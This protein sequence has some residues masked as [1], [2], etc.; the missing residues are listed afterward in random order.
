MKVGLK[1]QY[2]QWLSFCQKDFILIVFVMVKKAVLVLV[3]YFPFD[4][5]W[6]RQAFLQYDQRRG[7]PQS[8]KY[9]YK[10]TF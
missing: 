2:Q 6:V 8:T 10:Q 9:S 7:L 5:E 3:L 4:L 1:K